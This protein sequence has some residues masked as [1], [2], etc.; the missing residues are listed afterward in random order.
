MPVARITALTEQLRAD[1]SDPA[2]PGPT[3]EQIREIRRSLNL[4]ETNVILP[5][6]EE[7]GDAC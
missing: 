6:D 7:T 4:L 3:L 5:E 1:L 2:T